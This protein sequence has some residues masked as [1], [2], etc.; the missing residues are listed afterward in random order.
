MIFLNDDI[1]IHIFCGENQLFR[2]YIDVSTFIFLVCSKVLFIIAGVFKLGPGPP[3]GP[4]EDFKVPPESLL[5]I[6]C[7]IFIHIRIC[8]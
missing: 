5:N 7:F 6:I 1:G 3:K 2:K 8:F 4:P